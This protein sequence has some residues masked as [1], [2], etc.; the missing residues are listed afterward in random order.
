MRRPWVAGVLGVMLLAMSGRPAA[1]L[2]NYVYYRLSGGR[3]VPPSPSAGYGWSELQLCADDSLRGYVEFYT[4]GTPTSVHIHG[5]ADSLSNGPELFDL[6]FAAH[7][8]LVLLGPL[9]AVQRAWVEAERCYVDVH[10]TLHPDGEIRGQIRA[11]GDLA[12]ER[13]PWAR[14][15]RLYLPEAQPGRRRRP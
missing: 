9:S 7:G 10:T 12:V 11:E 2:C 6:P 8:A 5:P 15:K 3:V 1:A 4:T 13:S 14:V